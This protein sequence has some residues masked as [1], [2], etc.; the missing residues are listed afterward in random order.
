MEELARPRVKDIPTLD[1]NV[2]VGAGASVLGDIH[3]G[4]NV[5]IGANAVVIRDIPNDSTVVGV[6][7]RVAVR[8]GKKVPGINLDHTSLPDPLSQALGNLQHEIDHI[9]SELKDFSK[10]KQKKA[11][12]S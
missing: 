9:E 5:S 3:I 6:P 11:K 12:D 7:G 8:S 4:E 2:V 1:S 10:S